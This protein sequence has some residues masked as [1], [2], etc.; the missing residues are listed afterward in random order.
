MSRAR[1]AHKLKSMAAIVG[2]ASLSFVGV[3]TMCGQADFYSRFLMPAVHAV[4]DPEHAHLLGVQVARLQLLRPQR[5][6]DP[7]VLHTELFGLQFSNPIGLA[8]GF[9]KHAEG[10]PGAHD[11]GFGFVE[12]GSVTPLPQPG[13]PRPRVFRLA[14]DLAVVNRYGFNSVGHEQVWSSLHSSRAAWRGPVGVNLGRNKESSNAAADYVAG[15]HR[16]ADLADYLVVNVSSPNTPGLRTLQ[17]RHHLE[18]LLRKVLEARDSLP[19][20]LPVLVKIAP[21]LSD[22]EKADIAAAVTNTK[23]DGLVV[24]NTT[25]SRPSSLRS[26][27]RAQP[28]GLSGRPLR[29]LSTQTIAD[30]YRL[31]KGSIPIV[32]V[33]GVFSGEDAYAK[34]RAG[35]S[36]VQLYSALIYNGPPVVRTVKTRLAELLREGDRTKS[37][38]A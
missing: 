14:E 35:A 28:G 33:G 27:H 23:V 30:L 24:C 8:A 13:N 17:G 19:R 25:V 15:V 29:D 36:A 12:V 21:D 31:T 3:A 18:N 20:R 10:V 11:W 1:L 6:P 16:F 38:Q 26:E 37:W 4:L 5:E 22:E 7:D 2:G 9:D 32:G 34:I